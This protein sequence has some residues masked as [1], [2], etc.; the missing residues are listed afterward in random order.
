MS[1]A[2]VRLLTAATLI[3]VGVAAGILLWRVP[4]PEV[5]TADCDIVEDAGKQWYEMARDMRDAADNGVPDGYTRDAVAD[6]EVE[7]AEKLRHAAESVSTPEVAEQLNRWADS[8]TINAE[9]QRTGIP[10]RSS[11]NPLPDDIVDRMRD[12]LNLYT[13]AT[14][15]LTARCPALPQVLIG[16]NSSENSE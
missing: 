12:A 4:A 7:V 3:A 8:A 14:E 9:L 6:R 2:V 11:N 5:P 13:E 15:A 10:A 16:N 1:R